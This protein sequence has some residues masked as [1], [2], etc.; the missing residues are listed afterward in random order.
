MTPKERDAILAAYVVA[1]LESAGAT[2]LAMRIKPGP[3]SY[4]SGWPDIVRDAIEAYGYTPDRMRLPL[5][6]AAAITRMDAAFG[7]LNLIPGQQVALRRIVG[8]RCLV[9]PLTGRHL[10]SW[11]KVGRIIGADHRAVQGWH[12][13]GI[14]L[15]TAELMRTGALS[16]NAASAWLEEMGIASRTSEEI[17]G[18]I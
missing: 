4:G 5:P 15:I 13:K 18:K 14:S 12:A 17:C 1:N 8:A 10:A 6:S 3:A 9:H 11:R 16:T 2:L 7:W